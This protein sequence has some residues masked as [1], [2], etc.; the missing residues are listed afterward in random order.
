[1]KNPYKIVMCEYYEP[2]QIFEWIPNDYAARGP[3]K[4]VSIGYMI[5]ENDKYIV[6]SDAVNVENLCY[7]N[8]RSIPQES[9]ISMYEIDIE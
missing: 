6:L 2:N 7:N 3:S 9:I 8:A 5:D 1:M 4:I